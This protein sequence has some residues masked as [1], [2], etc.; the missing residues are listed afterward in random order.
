MAGGRNE[1]KTAWQATLDPILPPS[2][3]GYKSPAA[4]PP[5]QPAG[6]LASCPGEVSPSPLPGSRPL[7]SRAAACTGLGTRG[8]RCGRRTRGWPCST[9]TRSPRPTASGCWPR[10]SGV[11]GRGPALGDGVGGPSPRGGRARPRREPRA[12]GGPQDTAPRQILE[13]SEGGQ[14]PD[15]AH[16]QPRPS[17]LV[18]QLWQ[19]M[20]QRTP[21][22]WRGPP[23][24]AVITPLPE[25]DAEAPVVGCLQHPLPDPFC[26][27]TPPRPVTEAQAGRV[28]RMSGAGGGAQGKKVTTAPPALAAGVRRELVP[29]FSRCRCLPAANSQGRPPFDPQAPAKGP[30]CC[31]VAWGRLLRSPEPPG[32]PVRLVSRSPG[33]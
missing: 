6:Q 15:V 26:A 28:T 13:A 4:C 19:R 2:W 24:N 14:D 5:S 7:C 11:V 10:G 18:Q 12:A 16:G 23:P 17:C 1:G 33:P 30:G 8:G 27:L 21:P 22:G 25:E 31:R 3:P 20:G 9:C 32:R 29:S